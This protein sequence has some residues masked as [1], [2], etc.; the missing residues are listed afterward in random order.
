MHRLDAPPAIFQSGKLHNFPRKSHRAISTAEIA[1]DAMSLVGAILLILCCAL[2][3]TNYLVDQEIPNMLLEYMRELISNKYVFLL[4]L[5]IFLLIVGAMMDIFSAIIVV[6]PLILP[7]AE[8]FGIHPIHLA[9]IFL[10]NL[11]IGYITPPIGIN[12][13]I[14]SMR[15]KRPITHLY[16]VALPFV[17]ILIIALMIITYIPGLSLLWV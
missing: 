9:I 1:K 14:S 5:N 13:F 7:I 2:G 10:T 17:F 16:K 4:C 12:L 6:V 11:E 8:E 3:V 15:F